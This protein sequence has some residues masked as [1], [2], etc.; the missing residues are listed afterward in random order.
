MPAFEKELG[1]LRAHLKKSRLKQTAQRE[2]VLRALLEG[3]RYVT[4][5]ELVVLVQ[6]R[7]RG[8]GYSTVYRGMKLFCECGLAKEHHFLYGKTCF[9]HSVDGAPHDYL[10]C[11]QCGRVQEFSNPLIQAVQ[12]KVSKELDFKLQEHRVE[13][14]GIC[15]TCQGP[16]LSRPEDD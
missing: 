1:L 15:A 10:I 6:K 13:L 4:M 11:K 12:E 2:V 3:P 7:D 16:L 14:Y 9:E 5:D 8:I